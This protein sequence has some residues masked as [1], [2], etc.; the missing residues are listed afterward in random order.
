MPDKMELSIE[1]IEGKQPN[2]DGEENNRVR[3]FRSLLQVRAEG[4]ALHWTAMRMRC[5]SH[6]Q[7]LLEHFLRHKR[8]SKQHCWRLLEFLV[9]IA[10][11]S[12]RGGSETLFWAECA[13]L[14]HSPSVSHMVPVCPACWGVCLWSF[15]GG[16]SQGSDE[17]PFW[18]LIPSRFQ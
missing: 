6:I 9:S 3:G 17:V 13:L 18:S 14:P 2:F 7:Q 12:G 15:G 16:P 11:H 1:Y 8:V 10:L 4:F 5:P